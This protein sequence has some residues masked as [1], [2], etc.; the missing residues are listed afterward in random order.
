MR[1]VLPYLVLLASS[2]AA[3][4]AAA[5]ETMTGLKPEQIGQIFCLSR[6]G[7]DEA[8]IAG[9]LSPGLSAAIDEAWVKDAAWEAA[10][11][12]EKPPLGDG[13]PWQAWPDYAAECTVGLATLMKTDAKV[14]IAYGFPDSPDAN[15]SDTLLLT[16]I[17]DEALGI[18]R[19]RVDNVA[20]A[21]GGDLRAVLA[22]A[23]EGL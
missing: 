23:F 21:T 15:F 22:A 8:A 13:I 18:D 14:E 11:A 5:D 9:L 3:F 4:P 2:L 1:A 20:Y 6:V 17:T 16:R 12:G 10:N 7:N 19:W